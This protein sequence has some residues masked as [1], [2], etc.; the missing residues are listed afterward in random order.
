MIHRL[1]QTPNRK[2]ILALTIGL[3]Y[4]YS[5]LPHLHPCPP[6]AGQFSMIQC[7]I[8]IGSGISFLSIATLV[9]DVMLQVLSGHGEGYDYAVC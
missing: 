8:A 1:A 4:L 3:A 6:S 2:P 7:F 9:T 5:P